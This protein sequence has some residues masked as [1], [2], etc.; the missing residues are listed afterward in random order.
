MIKTKLAPMKLDSVG[1]KVQETGIG[2][3]NP[4]SACALQGYVVTQG[5]GGAVGAELGKEAAVEDA[6]AGLGLWGWR[7]QKAEQTER[8]EIKRIKV[9]AGGRRGGG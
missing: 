3:E 5:S 2:V 8:N 9:A 1:G 4:P 7:G 6:R